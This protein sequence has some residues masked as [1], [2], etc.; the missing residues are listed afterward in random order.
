MGSTAKLKKT[1]APLA[2]EVTPFSGSQILNSRH[3]AP[4][5]QE[6]ILFLPPT[7]RGRDP[8]YLADVQPMAHRGPVRDA[9]PG[10]EWGSSI[11]NCFVRE[12]F[13]HRRGC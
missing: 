8:I 3:L 2:V 6:Q 1:P 7:V 10:R 5:I 11:L 9:R 4:D 13:A 12:T